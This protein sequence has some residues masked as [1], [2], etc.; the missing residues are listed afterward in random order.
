MGYCSVPAQYPGLDPKRTGT[1]LRPRK[2]LTLGSHFNVTMS[3]H[4]SSLNN[5]LRGVGERVLYT[6]GRFELPVQPTGSVFNDKC[7]GFRR[8]V[9]R[10]VG[11]QSPVSRDSFAL[12]YKGHRNLL[13]TRAVASLAF[14]SVNPKDATL[15]TFVK[16]E[17][18]NLDAK[19]DPVPRVIQP[20]DPRYNVEVGR[21]LKPL[22]HK[23]YAAIDGV[24]GGPTIM[25]PYD[26][27]ALAGH[28]QDKWNS[29]NDPVCIGL[30]ASR[31]DQHVSKQALEFEHGLYHEIFRDRSLVRLLKWQVDNRGVARADD[32][33]FRYRKVG[34]RAS[35]DMNTSM[36]N[37]FLMCAVS[38][39]Y[40]STKRFRIEFANNGDDCLMFLERK[41]LTKLSDLSSWYK[42]F[43]FKLTLEAPVYDFE[44]VEFC[45]CRPIRGPRGW[46]MVRK[47]DSALLKDLTVVNLGHNQEE[48]LGRMGMIGDCGLA[49]TEDIPVFR[50]FYQLCKR[51]GVRRNNHRYL[52]E[53]GYY[54]RCHGV[55]STGATITPNSRYS[56]WLSTGIIPDVQEQLEH[57]LDS[58][59]WG[60]EERQVFE[61][62]CTQPILQSIL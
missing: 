39:S 37:K 4:N 6:N 11:H 46:R 7:G 51:S 27:F 8:H 57:C 35:G 12:L 56:F 29:F 20:R 48:Y 19:P 5:L 30:D 36:G 42:R 47:V 24:F 26:P 49:V 41:H 16:A 14:K 18:L 61:S 31:F 45:Q 33:W 28:L 13:Y 62:V 9:A 2:L 32:G 55:R 59:S 58:T 23:L 60:L 38:H 52:D 22:E 25:S 1:P 10:L 17:K 3:T 34:G 44:R 21:F 15:K 50:S 40:I 43:G 53:Y 54:Y